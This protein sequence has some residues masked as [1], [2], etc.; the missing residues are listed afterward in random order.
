MRVPYVDLPA[1]HGPL[2]EE[3]LAAVGR[4]LDHGQFVLGPEVRELEAR[5]A[6]YLGVPHVVTCGSGTD[7]LVLALRLRGIGPGDEVITVSH[8][9]V[10]TATAIAL[11]G[12]TP[13]FAD[14]D[15]RTMTMDAASAKA[16]VTSR[17]R[18]VIPVH[19]NG[20]PCPL[21]DIGVE[22]IEDCAQAFGAGRLGA[23]VGSRHIGCFSFH[24]L[25]VLSACGD[26]GFVTV[27]ADADAEHLRQLR[28]NGL[29]DRDHCAHRSANSRLDT[30]QAAMLLVKLGRVDDWIGARR[31]HAAAY[32]D[33]LADVVELPP[34]DA[35]PVWS[36]FVVRHRRRDE[37]IA[38]LAE[39]GVDAKVH[40][41]VAV[42]QQAAFRTGAPGLPV[43][44]KIVNEIVSLP[45]TPEMSAD[46][47]AHVVASVRA[48]A[49]ALA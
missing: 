29:V 28:N 48:A 44:E 31:D 49:E 5:L 43:T 39:A 10:T 27:H 24:P 32:C 37:L 7:A 36:A 23:R 30:V 17:T 26:G 38:R 8:T 1:Q 40:Y 2:R 14:I 9:F 3:L 16:A 46:Q 25:K 45:V 13:V 20:Y 15:P 18:A 21:P 6:A 47:R 19:L 12:A 34:H 33:A 11:V 4:V 42:H 35:E 22:I 41:P